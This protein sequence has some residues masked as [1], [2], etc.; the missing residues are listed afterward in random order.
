[1]DSETYFDDMGAKDLNM[2]VKSAQSK[3][4]MIAAA[5]SYESISL[6]CQFEFHSIKVKDSSLR[7]KQIIIK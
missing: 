2:S 1:M 5:E 7:F 6:T 4:A 3:T